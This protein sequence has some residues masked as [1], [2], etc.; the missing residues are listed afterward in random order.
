[1]PADLGPVGTH[2]LE[3]LTE[4]DLRLLTSVH[5]GL[6]LTPD[7]VPALLTD[8]AVFETVFAAVRQERIDRPF[9]LASPFLTFAVAVQ[10][11]AAD[12]RESTYVA[13]WSGPRQR[14]PVF[15]GGV[16]AAFLAEPWQALF[17]TELLASY[18]H[19]ASGSYWTKTSRG[20]RRRR[21]S[22]LDPARLAGLLEVVP[23]SE[24]SGVYRR[25]GDLA[26]F[27]TGVFPDHTALR[28]LRPI[29]VPRLLAAAGAARDAEVA[30]SFVDLLSWLGERWYRRA[31][32]SAVLPTA[33]T[34]LLADIAEHFSDARRALNLISD[35]Y[36]F[37]Y[38]N[39]WF[40]TPWSAPE[41]G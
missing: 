10:R 32:S 14:L 41:A 4:A 40:S 33:D 18:A 7:R 34:Q 22:E 36:L 39:Q 13:E 3:R 30:T 11:T 28:G 27:L 17:L 21:W 16:L 6:S 29:E 2:Y 15:D 20:W 31:V 26:L 23:E 25:L 24:R 35:R 38:G 1:M 12:V 5:P 19:V 8:D 37:P 9:V